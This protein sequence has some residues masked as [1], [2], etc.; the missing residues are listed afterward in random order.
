M[1]IIRKKLGLN[2]QQ[3]IN[4]RRHHETYVM[5]WLP[6]KELPN[7]NVYCL[8]YPELQSHVHFG[9]SWSYSPSK[10]EEPPPPGLFDRIQDRIRDPCSKGPERANGRRAKDDAGF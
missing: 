2:I 9:S 5:G 7:W 8:F 10:H 6:P 1:L 3:Y 4:Q